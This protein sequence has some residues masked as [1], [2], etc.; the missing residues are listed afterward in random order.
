MS[1]WRRASVITVKGRNRRPPLKGTTMKALRI[2]TTVIMSA[3]F[4]FFGISK[5]VKSSIVTENAGWSR[6][7]EWQ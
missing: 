5:I 6:L 4:G 2:I 1:N 3:G 7:A